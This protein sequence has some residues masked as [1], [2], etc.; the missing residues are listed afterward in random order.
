MLSA[1]E[2]G[3]ITNANLRSWH[4]YLSKQICLEDFLESKNKT[5]MR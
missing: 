2:I 1:I 4:V 3:L 5:S